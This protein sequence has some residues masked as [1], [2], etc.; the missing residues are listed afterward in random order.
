[1]RL[2]LFL[3][4]LFIL[5]IACYGK[6]FGPKGF[7]YGIGMTLEGSTLKAATRNEVVIS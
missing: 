5:I 2:T 4:F 7:G 3:N 6:S 1:M